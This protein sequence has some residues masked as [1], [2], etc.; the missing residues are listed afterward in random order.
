MRMIGIKE[1]VEMLKIKGPVVYFDVDDTLVSWYADDKL[2]TAFV[3]FYD[4]STCLNYKLKVIEENVEAMRCH[5]LR[6][7]AIVVWSAGGA[8]WAATVVAKLGLTEIVDLCIAKPTWFY[9][10]LK[11]EEFLPETNRRYIYTEMT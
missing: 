9:D 8:E 1:G 5:K 3:S 4:A 11:A 2:E 6:G 10:D 7:H